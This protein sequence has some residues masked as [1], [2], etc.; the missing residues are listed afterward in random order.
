MFSHAA[1]LTAVIIFIVPHLC[2]E[3]SLDIRQVDGVNRA[4]RSQE[5]R[6][7]TSH[8]ILLY[9]NLKITEGLQFKI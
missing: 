3:R 7:V 9:I 8:S 6:L 2:F 5:T 1:V 4:C